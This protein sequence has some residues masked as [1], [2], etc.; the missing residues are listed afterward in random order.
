MD[1]MAF[2]YTLQLNPQDIFLPLSFLVAV[3]GLSVG[4]N[5]IV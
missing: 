4:D 3:V 5:N 2:F 1:A